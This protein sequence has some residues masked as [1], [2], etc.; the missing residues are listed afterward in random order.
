MCFMLD[1]AP[2]KLKAR[3]HRSAVHSGQRAEHCGLLKRR[4]HRS[5]EQA[6]NKDFQSVK[7]TLMSFGA[8]AE[9]D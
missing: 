1:F 8:A 7:I 6:F 4:L 5:A 9:K 2:V 3:L